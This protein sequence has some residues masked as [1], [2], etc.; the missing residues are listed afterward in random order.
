MSIR[1]RTFLKATGVALA[2]PALEAM[3]GSSIAEKSK[4]QRMVLVCTTL[5]LHGPNFFPKQVGA[6]YEISPYLKHV[7]NYRNKMTVFSGLSHPDQSGA[8]GH[9]SEKTWLTGAIHP[10]LNGFQNTISIDQF[11][12]EKFGFVT[13]IPN[14]IL[15][16]NGTGSQSYTRNGVMVPADEKPSNVFSKLFLAGKPNEIKKQRQKLND[17]Q[18]I[19]DTLGAETKRIQSKVSKSDRKRLEEYFESIRATEKRFSKANE[20]LDKPKPKVKEKQPRDVGDQTDLIGRMNLLMDLI[21]LVVETD[22]SRVIVMQIAGRGDVP[23]IPGVSVGH[24]NLSHHG[25]DE[26]KIAQL[27]KVENAIMKAMGRLLKGLTD[28][29]ESS[30]SL[31]DNTMVLFGSNLGNA[32]SHDWRN[33]PIL[34]AGGDF[35]HGK[36]VA[37]DAKDNTPLSNLYVTM[38]RKMGI[39]VDQFSTSN[40]VLSW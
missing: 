37:F 4:P 22:S 28:R 18:S 12:A 38:L 5:G 16:T 1:R 8:S 25:Q 35:D 30:T 20:W 27:E 19:L 17:G 7:E 29:K 13:R 32:N 31:L 34:F 33:L 39:E 10:D 36:H 24:H 26:E 2:L 3:G 15:N 23:K 21:P 9:S 40:G 11:V 6:D 14:L